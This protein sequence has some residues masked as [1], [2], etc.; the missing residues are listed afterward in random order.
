ML[1]EKQDEGISMLRVLLSATRGVGG[2]DMLQDVLP[3]PIDSVE[4][5]E[6]LSVRLEEEAFMKKMVG[7][8]T[9]FR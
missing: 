5:L 4:D 8:C 1:I 2:T 3:K 7:I 9:Y 6:A